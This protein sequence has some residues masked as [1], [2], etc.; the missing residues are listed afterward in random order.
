[1]TTEEIIELVLKT[2]GQDGL[3]RLAEEAFKV[4]DALEKVTVAAD[5]VEKKSID[6]S[7]LA[8]SG[9]GLF[10]AFQSGELPGIIQGIGSMVEL[11]PGLNAFAPAIKKI[12]DVS[13]VAWPFLKDLYETFTKEPEAVKEA[14]KAI[15]D[16]GER[17]TEAGETVTNM[18]DRQV[19]LNI[20]LERGKKA[21]EEQVAA[22]TKLNA[23]QKPQGPIEADEAAAEKE[24][25]EILSGALGGQQEDVIEEVAKGEFHREWKSSQD[26]LRKIGTEADQ[27]TA[28]GEVVSD[29]ILARIEALSNRLELMNASGKAGIIPKDIQD[30]ARQKAAD[31]VVGGKEGAIRDIVGML[32][33]GSATRDILKEQLPEEKARRDA[34]RKA[35][36]DAQ[37]KAAMLKDAAAAMQSPEVTADRRETE[38]RAAD[39]AKRESDNAAREAA[40]A[41]RRAE[42]QEA[43]DMRAFLAKSKE[44]ARTAKQL[45]KQQQIQGQTTDGVMDLQEQMM[46]EAMQNR[47]RWSRAKQLQQQNRTAQSLGIN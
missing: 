21:L 23:L 34:E 28:R 32:P 2:S 27:A 11:V 29:E 26:E 17:L 7:A 44:D 43:Q 10:T 45:A 37:Q 38:Q 39:Q 3:A 33:E 15:V 16:Y 47:A 4:K 30:R 24:R 14:A 31:A 35:V 20:E 41:Q 40:N 5:A 42:Q 22:V 8:A 6:L 9:Q 19:S 25:S 12:G 13:E 18:T 1:M 46:Q 36:E